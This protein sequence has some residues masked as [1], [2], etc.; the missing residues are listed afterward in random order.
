MEIKKKA[1]FHWTSTKDKV[2]WVDNTRRR[3]YCS[4]FSP[5]LKIER[6]LLGKKLFLSSIYPGK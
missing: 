6:L 3:S 5:V 1:I 2:E 4:N